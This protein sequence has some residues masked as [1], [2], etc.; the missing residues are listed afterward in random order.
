M[1]GT[2]RADGL[3]ALL[4]VQSRISAMRPACYGAGARLSALA[5]RLA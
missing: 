5:I 3:M 2:L 4:L 1:H